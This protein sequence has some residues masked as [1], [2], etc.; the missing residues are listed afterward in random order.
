MQKIAL[1]Q[2]SYKN[3]ILLGFVLSAL[4]ALCYFAMRVVLA[5]DTFDE[6]SL[7]KALN[8]DF[9]PMFIMGFRLDMRAVCI[10]FAVI[11]LLGYAVGAFGGIFRTLNAKNSG[12]KINSS[13]SKNAL[14]GG[15]L[16]YSL[17][18]FLTKFTLFFATLSSFL[19]I[20]SA[21]VNVY[22][23][24]T[25][26][27]KIDI[28]IFGLK[29]DDTEA[30]LRIIWA[31]Y[32]ALTILA[33]SVLFAFVCFKISQKILNLPLSNGLKIQGKFGILLAFVLNLTLVAL[34]FVGIRG[35]VGTFPLREDEHHI[36]ANPLINH[37]ATNPIIAFAW[38]SEHYKA[39]ESFAP[40]DETQLQA[41]QN[42]LFP[43]FRANSSKQ[44]RKKPN[45]VAVLMESFGSNLLLLDDKKDFDL[46]MSFRPHFEVGKIKHKE[47][48]DFTFVNF[49]SGQNGTAG[50][51]A[52]L[53]FLSPSANISLS[54]A[55]NK[56]LPLTPFAVYKKAGYEVIYITSGNRSWQNFGDYIST[57]GADGVY[58]SNFLATHY[59]QS[60]EFQSVY[61]VGDEFAYKFALELLQNATKPLFIVILTTSNHPPYA[62]PLNF[63]APKF[64]LGDKKAFFRQ[65][66][67]EKIQTS[68]SVFSY[69]S[70]A[71]GEFITSVKASSFKDNTIVAMSGD[72]IYRDL[73]AYENAVLNHTVP[74]Y[75]YVPNAYTKDFAALGF[76]FAPDKLGSHKDIFPTLYA[77]S[78]N[79]CEFL[80]LGGRNLF[81]TKADER[82]NFAYNGAVWIDESGVYAKG[83]KEGFFYTDE[84][85]KKAFFINSKDKQSFE[86]PQNKAEFF[87][88]YNQLDWLQLNFR[89]FQLDN[90]QRNA[91]LKQN[92][93]SK[94]D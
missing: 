50:S 9:L 35:S 1:S 25:Y 78:L 88:K 42:E 76:D 15:A 52:S 77:L 17:A 16:T 4:Y 49:L 24:K 38:A 71:F 75:L 58:D 8:A 65:E 69:A 79:E 31:D 70:N 40:I 53:F 51:F 63:A 56:T 86:I 55:Q 89:L 87:D 47:Q 44:I 61:G 30:I 43:I 19:I 67:V 68:V 22:Y 14:G 13:N 64:D 60:K 20:I 34:V 80:S 83:A 7:L 59:P 6:F 41:L 45:V 48:S 85:G 3:F 54:R 57:L 92:T 21:L 18:G 36:S 10:A 81:D 93:N 94:Q 62:L 2:I 28:F 11:L 26:H 82:Y 91:N 73:K 37:I 66:S 5:F 12:D 39:Q 84:T 72:H 46:L 74:F 32:P 29:D 23:F 27:T 90:S 33:A